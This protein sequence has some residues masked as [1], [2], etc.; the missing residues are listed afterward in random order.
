MIEEQEFQVGDLVRC[1]G[2]NQGCDPIEIEATVTRLCEDGSVYLSDNACSADCTAPNL[3]YDFTI[4]HPKQLRLIRR[5][6]RTGKKKVW[7]PYFNTK[8]DTA[9]SAFAFSGSFAVKTTGY[10][11]IEVEVEEE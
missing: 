5:P 2:V 4:C 8:P 9:I 3:K 1:F 6:K 10:A 7:V 11:E